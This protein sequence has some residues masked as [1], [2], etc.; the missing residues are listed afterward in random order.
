[1]HFNRLIVDCDKL[2]MHTFFLQIPNMV[3]L[4]F[5]IAPQHH[6]FVVG[7][8]GYNVKHITERTGAKI[9]FPDPSVSSR[10]GTVNINGSLN[11]VIL[12]RGLLVVS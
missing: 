5:D 9:E 7:R 4:Q 10:K 8:S 12:A 6:V 2:C 11:A 1:M 3:S